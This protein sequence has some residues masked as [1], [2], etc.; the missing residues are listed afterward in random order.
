MSINLNHLIKPTLFCL[1]VF[2]PILATAQQPNDCQ[3][4][5]TVCGNSD[6]SL[7]VSGVGTQEL[8]NSNTCGSRENNSLWL[9]VNIATDGTLAFTLTPGSTSINE[10]YDFLFLDPM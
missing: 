6:F 9:L 4:A 7:D 2:I 8:N 3:F 5:V 10:D 1:I